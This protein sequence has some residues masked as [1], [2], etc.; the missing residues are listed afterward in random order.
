[1][2][3]IFPFIMPFFA[4][5]KMS[6]KVLILLLITGYYVALKYWIGPIAFSGQPGKPTIN[7]VSDFGFLRCMAGFMLGMLLYEFYATRFGYTILKN[8]WAFVVFFA[9][10][11]TAMHAGIPDL[12]IIAFFPFIIITAAYNTTTV[13][14]VL[15]WRVLQR[16][17]DW[18]FSLY[19]W[20]M[21]RW[22]TFFMCIKFASIPNCFR[23]KLLLQRR[24]LPIILRAVCCV[25]S[26]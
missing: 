16:L 11:L 26:C 23:G 18:S 3:M 12:L 15:E 19:T 22:C 21:Y 9:G 6:G 13:K 7:L 8:S 20:C 24:F 2:Y 25:L 1:M 17:G 4:R 14:K 5:I 10:V